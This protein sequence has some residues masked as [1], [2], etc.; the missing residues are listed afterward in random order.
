MPIT[1]YGTDW[2]DDTRR[3][4]AFLA[5][6]GARAKFIDIEARP[7]A[8]RGLSIDNKP[9]T[10]PVVIFDDGVR[11]DDPTED[12]LEVAF[13]SN[14][15]AVSVRHRTKLNQELRRFEQYR[16]AQL[17]AS[18]EFIERDRTIVIIGSRQ[19]EPLDASLEDENLKRLTSGLVEIVT[20]SG[21]RVD[22]DLGA[23]HDA[24]P[25]PAPEPAVVV[26]P[27]PVAG[28]AASGREPTPVL[29]SA[30]AALQPDAT[31]A[32]CALTQRFTELWS[33]GADHKDAIRLARAEGVSR[34]AVIKALHTLWEMPLTPEAMA[35]AFG[36][37]GDEDLAAMFHV[38]GWIIEQNPASTMSELQAFDDATGTSIKTQKLS[39]T[40]RPRDTI[41]M[42][43]RMG[44]GLHLR[45]VDE[46][47]A[48]QMAAAA[49]GETDGLLRIQDQSTLRLSF[50]WIFLYQSAEY[51]DSGDYSTMI[52]G[53]AP[54]LVD[55]FTG[56]LWVTGTEQRPGVYADNYAATGDPLS[57]SAIPS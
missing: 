8:M 19:H 16:D 20:G 1:I 53:N 9:I 32:T 41:A 4:R 28:P 25:M 10:I 50:G 13:G 15:T 38:L 33:G 55:R 22:I 18:A 40:Q 5:A 27:E 14:H 26:E 3:T 39:A 34:L 31:V 7:E 6:R 23:A 57:S 49:I 17:V 12:Q 35:L 47:H 24:E 44:P 37:A 36:E 30:S 11:L 45:T 42:V 2:C 21:R 46:A 43:D 56:A 52:S 48:R 54:L 51:M 29:G